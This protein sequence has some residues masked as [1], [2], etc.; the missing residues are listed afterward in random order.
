[1]SPLIT[2]TVAA[3]AIGLFY[4]NANRSIRSDSEAME[5]DL[6]DYLENDP[7][8]ANVARVAVPALHSKAVAEMS[9]SPLL[10][11]MRAKVSTS[12]MFGGSLDIFLAFQFTAVLFGAVCEILALTGSLSGLERL[13][14]AV[15]GV[16]IAVS[17]YAAVSD[18]AKKIAEETDAALPFFVEILQVAL[19]SA[20]SV[21]QALAFATR[22]AEDS[23]VSRQAAWLVTT[24]E[25]GGMPEKEA[26]ETAGR[27]LGSPDAL[28]FF[29]AL[30]QAASEG[31]S[32]SAILARQS[33]ALRKQ[34]HQRR[35]AAVKKIPVALVVKFAVHF[36]PLLFIVTLF[37]VISSF[38][39]I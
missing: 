20:M 2:L 8:M 16:G 4:M 37:P 18:K 13:G 14:L 21:Q 19:A 34:A 11:G 28:A 35:R 22:Q 9:M 6:D 25:T 32:V 10:R 38:Q 33:D 39:Q 3:L 31:T 12:G 26:Y 23:P 15:F 5:S 30:G 27:R 29:T 17:P 24:L 1:M 7:R 36:L